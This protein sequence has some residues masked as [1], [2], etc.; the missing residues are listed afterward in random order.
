MPAEV[1][2]GCMKCVWMV[3][4][5]WTCKVWEYLKNDFWTSMEFCDFCLRVCEVFGGNQAEEIRWNW[6]YIYMDTWGI[7]CK[8]INY[9]LK[10]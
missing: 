7:K 3:S 2:V 8:I 1:Y 5:Q 6:P 4:L 10:L 9:V